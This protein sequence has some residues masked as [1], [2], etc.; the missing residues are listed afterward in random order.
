VRH[1]VAEPGDDSGFVMGRADQ[2][3]FN[4]QLDMTKARAAVP[5]STVLM[6]NVNPGDPLVFGTPGQVHAAARQVIAATGGR[7]LF[8]SSGCAM[9]RNTPPENVQALVSAAISASA[10]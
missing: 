7:G 10:I 3:P 2:G 4:W 1:V 9:G 6:G 5:A 8:L